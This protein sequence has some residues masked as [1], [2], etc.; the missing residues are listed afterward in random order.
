MVDP[1]TTMMSSL[2]SLSQ[3]I[4]PTPPLIDSTMYCLS[5]VEMW[6]TVSPTSRETSLKRGSCADRGREKME[7]KSRSLRITV[8]CRHY[9][10][11]IMT[12]RARDYRDDSFPGTH[13][14]P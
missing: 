13:S 9:R 6:G 3:S 5:G 2:P 12:T 8:G 14:V 7:T 1:F 10:E 4:R 11:K